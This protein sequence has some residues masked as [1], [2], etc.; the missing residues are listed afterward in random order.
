MVRTALSSV[1]CMWICSA[2]GGEE[3]TSGSGGAGA[4]SS[5]GAT[6][7]GSGGVVSGTCPAA[8]AAGLGCTVAGLICTYGTEPRPCQ[9]TVWKCGGTTFA[10]VN[11]PCKADFGCTGP[12]NTGDSC[13]VAKV[14]VV[15]DAL[16]GCVVGA[17]SK[18]TCLSPPASCPA[19]IPNAGSQCSS[20]GADCTYGNCTVVGEEVRA[21]CSK[22]TWSWAARQC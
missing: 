4:T 1:L 6:S 2:C 11:Q 5:G 8:P 13:S 15:Q 14:C 16:C 7:G 18:W 20:E 3:F 12:I 19:I 22:G 9:R 17:T 21:R 10:Q